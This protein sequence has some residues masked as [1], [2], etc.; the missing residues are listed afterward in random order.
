MSASLLVRLWLGRLIAPPLNGLAVMLGAGLIRDLILVTP[1]YASHAYAITWEATLVPVLAAQS[2]ATIE[3]LRAIAKLY[4]KIASFAVR[5][6]SICFGASAIL[7]CCGLYFETRLLA[8]NE[9]ILR[10]FFLFDRWVH[11]LLAGTL[12]L[13]MLFFAC[14]PT[15]VRKKPVNLARHAL[16]L[17]F[18]F[19][20]YAIYFIAE[21]LAPLGGIAALERIKSAFVIALYV[22]WICALSPAGQEMSAWPPID[23]ALIDEVEHR[24]QNALALLRYAAGK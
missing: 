17:S 2:W 1:K 14:L 7:C 20:A 10:S 4:P 9:A 12:V 24:N 18:Y 16:L 15:P 6:F 8:G 5:L 13:T 22:S 11:S 21:N 23:P 3:V 19:G